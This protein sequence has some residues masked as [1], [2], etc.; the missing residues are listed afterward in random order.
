MTEGREKGDVRKEGNEG[1]KKRKEATEGRKEK[2]VM[3]EGNEGRKK[4]R[5]RRKE[6]RKEKSGS[7]GRNGGIIQYKIF[8]QEEYSS[9]KY[10]VSRDILVQNM[11]TGRT[12]KYET[13][14]Q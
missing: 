1:R 10:S 14:S 7:N 9:T 2:D 13:L 6:R 11:Q 3:K 12:F 8:S 4:G 5:E